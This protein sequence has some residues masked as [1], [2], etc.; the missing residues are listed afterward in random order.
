MSCK[1]HPKIQPLVLDNE[2]LNDIKDEQKNLTPITISKINNLLEP[3]ETTKN[4]FKERYNI[5]EWPPLKNDCAKT[6][7]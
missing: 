7:K 5:D 6:K 2:E 3:D 1:K 4:I